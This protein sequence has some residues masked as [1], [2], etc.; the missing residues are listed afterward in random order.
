MQRA[1]LI[2]YYL[3]RCHDFNIIFSL[4]FVFVFLIYF[5][6]VLDRRTEFYFLCVAWFRSNNIV[7]LF[8]ILIISKRIA[9]IFIRDIFNI[10]WRVSFVLLVV[11]FSLF[12]FLCLFCFVVG[13]F[14]VVFL[15]FVRFFVFI[16]VIIFLIS[17]IFI[18]VFVGG[19]EVSLM[20][21]FLNWCWCYL[22]LLP[23]IWVTYFMVIS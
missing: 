18:A 15:L 5:N 12:V 19:R 10:K 8:T 22:F 4:G 11:L 9:I 1:K 7:V 14:V 23:L 17:I 20:F 16:C 13:F 2:Q 21:C 3:E 6:L